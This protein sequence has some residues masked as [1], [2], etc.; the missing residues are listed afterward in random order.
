MRNYTG[1][2]VSG[3]TNDKTSNIMD[4]A[5]SDQYLAAMQR[6]DIERKRAQG[7]PQVNYTE[8]SELVPTE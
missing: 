6:L 1:I 7:I 8:R 4:Y 2:W 3:S 5:S